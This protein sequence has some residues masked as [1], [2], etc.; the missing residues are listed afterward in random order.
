[1]TVNDLKTYTRPWTVT[2]NQRLMADDELIEFI[3]GENNTSVP[4]LVGK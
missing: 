2:A 3:C 4:H 1:V